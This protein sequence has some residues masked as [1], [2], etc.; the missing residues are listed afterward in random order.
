MLKNRLLYL[1]M[2]QFDIALSGK[3]LLLPYDVNYWVPSESAQLAS[4]TY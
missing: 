1:G 4:H 3:L 2:I